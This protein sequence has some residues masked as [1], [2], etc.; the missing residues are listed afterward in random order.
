MIIRHRVIAALS[1]LVLSGCATSSPTPSLVPSDREVIAYVTTHWDY[2]EG[3]FAFLSDRAGQSPSLLSVTDVECQPD[4]GDAMCT[5]TA[6]GRFQDGMI[7]RRSMDSLFQRQDD[8]SIE[9]LIPV[10]AG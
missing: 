6:R 5:F 9:M 8:G 1:A 10:F 7:L 2:Y 3:R 4:D